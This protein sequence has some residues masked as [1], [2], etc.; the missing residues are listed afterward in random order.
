MNL[1][2]AIIFGIVYA[3]I[4]E[5]YVTVKAHAVITNLF[6]IYRI[7]YFSLFLVAT[8]TVPYTHWIAY[9]LISMSVEDIYY[10]IIA[11]KKP[12]QWTWY[13]IVIDGIPMIDVIE[14]LTAILLLAI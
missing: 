13:Y 14:I 2:I 7:L 11:G 9:W 12:F 8:Y 6:S 5:R 4:E 3:F 10:W 1:F